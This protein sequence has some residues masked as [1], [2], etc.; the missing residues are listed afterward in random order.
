M[1]C[2]N[3]I[4]PNNVVIIGESSFE[5]CSE[6]DSI[7][8]PSG[9]TKIE[10][11]AFSNCSNLEEV[12]L[13]ATLKSIGGYAFNNCAKL[14]EVVIPNNVTSIG[15]N[16]D[17]KKSHKKR[18]YGKPDRKFGDFEILLQKIWKLRID[19][20]KVTANSIE[21]LKVGY[22]VICDN[23]EGKYKEVFKYATKG[24]FK[25]GEENALRGYRDFVPLEFTL[26]RR[27]VIQGYGLLNKFKFEETIE[28]DAR[29]DEEYKRIIET[30]QTIENPVRVFEF[31]TEINSELKNK[32]VTYISRSTIGELTGEEYEQ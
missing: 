14:S 31:L 13:P 8:I 12:Q 4:I 22:S 15:Y 24:V 20:I 23:A 7:V 1:G 10:A 28:Q 17:I 18:E 9:I 32:N 3:S 11:Y 2:K 16:P 29:A 21:A 6:L 26:Y 5:L 30:L 19:G 25:E 27:K